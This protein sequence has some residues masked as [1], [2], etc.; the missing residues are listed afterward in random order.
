MDTV[1][2]K[3]K[4]VLL[5]LSGEALAGGER[6]GIESEVLKHIA[7]EIAEAHDAGV[8]IGIVTGGG[9]IFRGGSDAKRCELEEYTGHYMGM[10]ATVINGLALQGALETRGIQTRLMTAIEMREVAEPYIQ[11]RALRHLEKRRIV[12]FA[13]GTGHPFFTTDTAAVLRAVQMNAEAIFK[14]TD[15]DGVYDDDPDDKPDARLFEAIEYLQV[16]AKGYKVMDATAI[17]L[18]MERQ[19]PIIVFNM[20]VPGNI[21][22][23]LQGQRVGTTVS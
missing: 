16:L 18:S 6:R 17:S 19:L 4:R 12:I 21:S 9:N 11:R 7:A 22:R 15:V 20:N 10:L 13:A 5:K 2:P 8:D 1:Q 3:Y 14:G 23:A